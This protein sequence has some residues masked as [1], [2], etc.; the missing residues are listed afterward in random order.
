MGDDV[1]NL[2]RIRQSIDV[3]KV[4]LGDLKRFGRHVRNVLSNQLARIDRRLV[5]LLQQEAPEWLD[6]RPEE[7]RVEWHIDSLERDSGKPSL[8]FQRLGL[9]LGL[10]GAF[11]NDVN[12]MRLDVVQRHL[13]HQCLNINFLNLKIVGHVGETIQ[14]PELP[15]VSC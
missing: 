11:T 5:D 12:E 6:A 14:C 13:L 3:L 15:V 8:E 10:L 4:L 1:R 2:G 9:G 7:S